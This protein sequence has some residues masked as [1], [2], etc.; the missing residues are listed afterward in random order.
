M[1]HILITGGAGFIGS[2]L[3]ETL[4]AA[5][6]RVTAL[7]DE[8]SGSVTNLAACQQ[9][10][11]F[12]YVRGRVEDRKFLRPLLAEVDQVY[13]LASAVGVRMIATSTIDSMT[14][15]LQPTQVLLEELTS[16]SGGSSCPQVFLA[17]SSEVYGKNP[18]P[19]FAEDDNLVFGP[20]TCARWSY[21]AAKA[22]D[23]FLALA[24]AR[25]HQL[26]VVVGRFFNVVGPRQTGKYG[27]VLPSMVRR[28]LDGQGPI[29][30]DDGQQVRCFAHVQD[31]CQAVLQLMATPAAKGQI[32]N[33][34]SDE[35]VT[36]LKLA[37]MIV[38]MVNPRLTIQRQSYDEVYSP[39]FEDVRRRVPDLTKLRTVI[40]YRQQFTLE[41]IV[42]EVIQW[43]KP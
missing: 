41:S 20:T 5:G 7:D 12:N 18:Q 40:D 19:R 24:Y 43:S 14:R 16:L 9:Q 39:G 6:Q 35:P 32:F 11:H 13:H 10:F 30:H 25:E 34:G 22:I 36:M 8:S 29:V 23:E 21:G 27:M 37:E 15:I 42:R 31:V 17:S 2:H 1:K 3:A 26:P 38:E 28:A 4:L 33:I